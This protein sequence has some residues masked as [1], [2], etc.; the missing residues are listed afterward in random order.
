MGSSPLFYRVWNH[1]GAAGPSKSYEDFM[2]LFPCSDIPNRLQYQR[3]PACAR[4][5][6]PGPAPDGAV[7][8]PGVET[9]ESCMSFAVDGGYRP[10]RVERRRQQLVRDLARIV[11]AAP[12]PAVALLLC[13][14]RLL[15]YTFNPLSVYFCYRADGERRQPV[16]PAWRAGRATIILR[17]RCPPVPRIEA[18]SIGHAKHG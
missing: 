12:Q 10:L 13:Y 17:R 16:I 2:G 9:V 7:R 4:F 8:H 11:R 1:A 18:G 15:G 6:T 14:P 5:E 3:I